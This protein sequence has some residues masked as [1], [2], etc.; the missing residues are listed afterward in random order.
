MRKLW[1][2]V[3]IGLAILGLAV[4][5]YNGGPWL[6]EQRTWAAS[7][8]F[9]NGLPRESL[10]DGAWFFM[11]AFSTLFALVGSSIALLVTCWLARRAGRSA[12]EA[13]I[14]AILAWPV[15]AILAER[16]QLAVSVVVGLPSDRLVVDI[17]TPPVEE[18]LLLVCATAV[19][20][21]RPPR[22]ARPAIAFGLAAGIGMNVFE[23]AIYV[24]QASIASWMGYDSV[25]QWAIVGLR[26]PLFG[27]GLHPV[28]SAL[29]TLGVG[30]SLARAPGTR[31]W[32]PALAA[33]GASIAVHGL[34]NA[35]AT[36]LSNR[37]AH[38]IGG[39]DGITVPA[40]AFA[41]GSI[42]ALLY[43]GLPMLVLA[44]GWRRAAGDR[45]APVGIDEIPPLDALGSATTSTGVAT[46]ATA[47]D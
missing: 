21:A 39:F 42:V 33:I 7:H 8:H 9:A 5:V 15:F 26:A 32:M 22:G 11:V 13:I 45:A 25:D 30:M 37:I 18:L 20:V 36:Q 6:Q 46:T 16:M 34:W 31:R 40:V 29:S 28:T 3:A 23:T 14:A 1:W 17:L 35:T 27:F 47:L 12:S 19:L 24:Q 43:L 10:S 4:S 38:Q 44:W 41:S 2:P